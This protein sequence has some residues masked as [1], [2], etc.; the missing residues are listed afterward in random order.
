MLSNSG[1]PVKM[2]SGV[3]IIGKIFSKPFAKPRVQKRIH[4]TG[5]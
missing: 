4:V 3:G 1:K 2:Y 5:I